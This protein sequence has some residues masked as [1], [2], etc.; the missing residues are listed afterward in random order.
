MSEFD[1][2]FYEYRKIDNAENE[3]YENLVQRVNEEC[4]EIL[5]D[6]LGV[7]FVSSCGR[8]LASEIV[9]QFFDTSDYYITVDQLAKRMF[10]FSYE[11]EYDPLK[12]DVQKLVYN[13][14]ENH[15]STLDYIMDINNKNQENLFVKIEN[16]NK[17]EYKEKQLMTK[18]KGA[19]ANSVMQDDGTI[20]DEYTG[21][22]GEYVTNV[23]GNH[24]RRQEVDHIQAA[25]TVTYNKRYIKEKGVQELKEM[26]NSPDNF[27]MMDKIANCSKGDVRVYD[28]N[29]ND[30][31]Y[32]ATPEQIAEATCKRW[33][34]T[35]KET[36]QKL[37][38]KGYLNE[39]GKVPESVKNKLI[40]NIRHSQ[41]VESK[42]ILKNTNYG[43]VSKDAAV[44]TT[45]SLYKIIGGQVLYYAT[46]PLIFEVKT[47]LKEKNISIDNALKKLTN[48]G[49]RI[50]DYVLSHLKDIFKNIAFNSI[51]KFVKTFMNILIDIVKATVKKMLK[52][53][54]S[55]VLS[56][57]DSV[58]IIADKERSGAEKADAVFSLFSVTITN[59]VIECLFEYIEKQIGLPEFLLTPFQILTS[60][61]CSNFVM[62]VLK[63][64]DIFDVRFGLKMQKIQQ[65][66]ENAQ[67]EF[68]E[69]C[70]EIEKSSYGKQDEIFEVISKKQK[71]IQN[72]LN[73]VNYFDASIREDLQ[74][75]S[76]LFKMNIDFENE[77]NKFLGTDC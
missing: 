52:M 62:L 10:T 33:E 1:D 53:A 67:N 34:N 26:M 12:K 45:K 61:I 74:Q 15:S 36:N 43:Q 6:N 51:K 32:R 24:T 13:Y 2:L 37:Q 22:K 77:W 70:K 68:L 63:K 48:A 58:R 17:K 21:K 57:V 16:R 56:V 47:I 25:A 7:E 73:A 35:K 75:I 41:N 60:V 59:I 39:D 8:D 9:R 71:A 11:N 5:K 20:I 55:L 28:K 50:G 38:D 44:D 4:K 46:P 54:K 3:L 19:Y 40:E 30:I 31:T 42:V 14:S 29:G 76:D 72:H 64:L 18:G 23:N 66:F 49:K 69:G 27:A 65:C